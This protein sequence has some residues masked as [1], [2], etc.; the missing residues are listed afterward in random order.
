M[1]NNYDYDLKIKIIQLYKQGNKPLYLSNLFQ[2]SLKSIYNWIYLYNN[3]LLKHKQK[4][5]KKTSLFRNSLI[6][7]NIKFYIFKNPSFQYIK[8]I[9]FLFK[10]TNIN[11]SKTTLYN[12]IKDLKITKKIISLTKKYGKKSKI[13]SQIKKLKNKIKNINVNNIISIDEIGFDTN[14]INN[15]AWALK[16]KRIFKNIGATYKRLTVICTISNHTVLHYKILNG[17]SNA[18]T[19]LDFIKELNISNNQYILLDNARIHHALIVKEY[20]NNNNIKF[21]FNVPYCPWFNPIEFIFSKFKKIVKDYKNNNFI[22]NLTNNIKKSIK[23]IKSIDLY[24]SFN[25]SI[26]ILLNN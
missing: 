2:V 11:I 18:I 17:S 16:G 25:H 9:A 1:K 6:R 20:L 3:N 4:Y 22:T 8:L 19:F 14:I 13:T 10:K 15:K 21:L 23:K 12:I 7:V 5:I 24:N 26:N